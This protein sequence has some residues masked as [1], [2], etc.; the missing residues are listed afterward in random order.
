M[1]ANWAHEIDNSNPQLKKKLREGFMEKVGADLCF[2]LFCGHGTY[3]RELY[4]DH[5]REVVCVDKKQD[6]LEDLPGDDHIHAYRGDNAS[7]VLG[8]VD[9]YGWPDLWD[10]DAYGVPDAALWRALK[11]KPQKKRF[12]VVATDGTFIGRQRAN[13]VP[14]HWDWG[15]STRWAPFSAGRSD[16][17]LLVRDNLQ[18]WFDTA[19]YALTLFEAILPR[20][21][22][23]VYWASLAEMDT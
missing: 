18:R 16:Y 7:L 22:S 6:A 13:K 14:V 12:A 9:R 20:G 8:L 17:P 2:D 4:R 21:Q 3:C 19:G 23:V 5:F 1:P 11:M 10:L 15:K